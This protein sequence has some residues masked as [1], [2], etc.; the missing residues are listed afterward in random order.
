ME[1]LF[2][3]WID[4]RQLFQH[5]YGYRPRGIEGMLS[6]WNLEFR[7]R[8]HRGIDDSRNIASIVIKMM[9]EGCIF[10]PTAGNFSL[11]LS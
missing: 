6:Q 10:Y 9:Q 7:G 11:S 1:S 8:P 3:T 4:C 5:F 2:A